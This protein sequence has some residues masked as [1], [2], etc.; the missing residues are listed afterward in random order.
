M[1]RTHGSINK[2]KTFLLNRLQE[3]YG[4]SFHPVIRM[5]ENAVLLQ[6]EV[7]KDPA[8]LTIKAA[9][10]GWDKIAAYTSPK[11]KAVEVT[12][13]DGGPLTIE[14]IARSIVQPND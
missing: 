9:I 14:N 4:D 12:G 10:D 13:E 6:D 1:A 11:L 2:N 8:P 5:A 3:M 7:D